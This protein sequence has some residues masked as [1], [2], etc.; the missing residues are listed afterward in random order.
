MHDKCCT[1]LSASFSDFTGTRC[2]CF[3]CTIAHAV[4]VI[5][6]ALH[7]RSSAAGAE[8]GWATCTR[9]LISEVLDPG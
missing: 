8:S 9:V 3:V 5:K 1:L 4:V 6:S 7:A 2:C